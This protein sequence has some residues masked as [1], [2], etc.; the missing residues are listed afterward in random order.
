MASILNVDQINN[1]AGTSAITIDSNGN[2]LMA[3]HVVDY[4]YA[5]FTS[6]ITTGSTS[7]VSSGLSASI[8]PKSTSNKLLIFCNADS[9]QN[10]T[11]D[12][13]IVT[14]YRGGVSSGTNLGHS[15]YGLY[16]HVLF[17][18]AAGTMKGAIMI[19]DTPSTTSAV[20]YEVAFKSDNGSSLAYL[21]VNEAGIGLALME[22]AQ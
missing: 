6:P 5:S 13:C 22:I 8:T 15:D 20:T 2:A 18:G 16:R 10:A 21:S 3:G 17:N 9:Y 11:N 4:Q 1:A 12:S 19:E 7:F 14:I